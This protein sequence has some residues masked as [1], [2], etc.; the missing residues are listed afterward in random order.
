[1]FESHRYKLLLTPVLAL[2]LVAAACGG[3]DDAGDLTGT[4]LIDGSSTV[5]PLSEAAAELFQG[6]NPGV[7]VTVGTSGTS[8][9]FEKFCIGETDI[10]D[11]S[12]PI[13]E[14]EIELCGENSID[15]EAVQVANDALSIVVNPANPVDCLTKE[16]AT[17]IWDAGSKVRTWG[18]VD[19]LDLAADVASQRI[20]LYGP[21]TDSGTFD[22]FTEVI[23]GEEGRIR[24]DYVSIGED[25][26]AAIVGVE[27]DE[28]AMAYIP[29]S[30]VTEAADKVKP[31]AIDDG[32]GCVE[33]TLENV[34]AGTYTPLGRGLFIYPS[35]T[36][37]QQPEVIEF[38]RFYINNAEPVAEAA[39][40]ISL[41]PE[42][43]EEQLEVVERL[44]EENA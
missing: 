41:T 35:G 37:L 43:I 8:G 24:N 15:Y 31:L 10:S 30:F 12:R 6:E 20:T 36:A 26:Q 4:I 5:A 28:Y 3:S 7:R 38:I 44:A 19:G 29:Y 34:Q 11:A 2:A 32:N 23:N 9:G 1:M 39:S 16:Q 42:Q 25:D 21:G 27:G 13:K 18:D 22:F 33:A 40:F 17:Q 14:S